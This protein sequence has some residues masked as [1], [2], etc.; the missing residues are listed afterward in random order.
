M[1]LRPPVDRCDD[2]DGTSLADREERRTRE[3]RRARDLCA[4]AGR[5]RETLSSYP[6]PTVPVTDGQRP[7]RRQHGGMHGN[8]GHRSVRQRHRRRLV[9]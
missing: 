6:P 3:E 5:L 2:L 4:A 1:K 9:R 7:L 8:V